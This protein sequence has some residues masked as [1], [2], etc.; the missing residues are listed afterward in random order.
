MSKRDFEAIAAIIAGCGYLPLTM[1]SPEGIAIR[2]SLA[3]QFAGYLSAQYPRF[4][5][6]LFMSECK[7]D[8]LRSRYFETVKR[9][10]PK[11]PPSDPEFNKAED[12]RVTAE[13]KMRG[14]KPVP[15]FPGTWEDSPQ[16][17]AIREGTPLIIDEEN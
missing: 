15:D 13:M 2:D 11:D 10:T 16:T 9:L 4:N 7:S 6:A 14:F 17:K 5:E 8:A 1:N 3:A 12:E